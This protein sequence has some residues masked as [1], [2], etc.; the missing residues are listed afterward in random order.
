MT[1]LGS[2]IIRADLKGVMLLK[3]ASVEQKL[4]LKFIVSVK[5]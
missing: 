1:L 3:A 2:T 5:I 4:K